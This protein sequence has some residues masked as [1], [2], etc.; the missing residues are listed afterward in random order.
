MTMKIKNIRPGILVIPDGGLRLLPGQ[1]VEVSEPTRQI[2]GLIASG[3]LARVES[4]KAEASKAPVQAALGLAMEA[5]QVPDL[6]KMN[7]QEAIASVATMDD[8]VR[9]KEAL[10]VE[11]RRTV[12]DALEKKREEMTGGAQ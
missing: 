4:R 7:A 11:K 10:E 6:S 3:H 8:P 1:Q 2:E 12:L 5:G 9:I